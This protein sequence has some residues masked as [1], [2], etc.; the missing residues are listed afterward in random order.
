M[1]DI[2]EWN[3]ITAKDKLEFVKGVMIYK[4]HNCVDKEDWEIICKFLLDEVKSCNKNLDDYA[5]M[6][7]EQ[8]QIIEELKA[9]EE[10]TNN[11]TYGMIFREFKE[12]NPS[13]K[14]EDYR[15]CC[16]LYDVPNINNAIVIWLES[17]AKVIYISQKW[18]EENDL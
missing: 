4:L 5:K 8:A 11:L 18:R 16:E 7:G 14:V 3:N 1:I 12:A 6:L 10:K 2:Q 17:G 13:I 15:P 9:R